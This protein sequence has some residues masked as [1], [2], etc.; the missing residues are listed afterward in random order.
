M[1][2]LLGRMVA[3]VI[4]GALMLVVLLWPIFVWGQTFWTGIYVGYLLGRVMGHLASHHGVRFV[5]EE[6]DPALESTSHD[7][8]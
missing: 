4:V 2:D 8:R 7:V 1:A 5:V 6:E 3:M